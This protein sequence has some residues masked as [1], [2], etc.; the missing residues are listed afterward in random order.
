MHFWF[1]IQPYVV[2]FDF[3][4]DYQ[5]FVQ[6]GKMAQ[7]VVRDLVFAPTQNAPILAHFI[8]NNI[9]VILNDTIQTQNW[10]DNW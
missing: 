3:L 5:V 1:Y 2:L 7:E 8:F 6:A 9:S 10:F 4:E